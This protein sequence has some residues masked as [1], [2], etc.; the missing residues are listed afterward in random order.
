[1]SPAHAHNQLRILRGLWTRLQPLDRSTPARL[2][3]LL[4]DRRFGGR[5]R[6][7]YRELLLTALRHARTLPPP[8][9]INAT[10]AD[11]LAWAAILAR[12][13]AATRE[14]EAFRATFAPV[15]SG[16]APSAPDLLSLMPDWFA[17][18]CDTGLSP[19]DTASALLA[20]APLWVRLQT[21][22]PAAVLAEWRAL[23]WTAEP[24]PALPDAFKLPPETK[25][26]ACPLYQ[27]GHYE[28]QDAGSQRI[29]ADVLAAHP[30]PGPRWLDACAGAGGK[31][32]Q[33]ARLLGPAARIDA[34]DPRAAALAELRARATRA[35][36]APRIRTLAAASDA[37]RDYDGVLVDAP[38][39]GSGTWRRAP[40]LMACTTR[41]DLAAAAELQRAI[42]AEASARVRPGGLLVYA[43]CSIARTEN[44]LVAE[45]FLASHGNT[46]QPSSPTRPIAPGVEDNDGF[47]VA[48]FR[49]NS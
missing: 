1:M 11:A 20:R 12:A 5:D 10:E 45:G 3:T 17:D 47:Y 25:V 8:G 27:A 46:F 24:H 7:L 18:E 38:C 44:R 41:A 28:I 23:G 29:L 43:T 19:A 14:T 13:C 15:D 33:L 48:T 36:L 9:A 32:L 39:A 22:S 4:A 35:G 26:T 49:R 37:S 40:H 34:T 2:Q 21:D 42:L 30:A 31:T 16:T 6:R